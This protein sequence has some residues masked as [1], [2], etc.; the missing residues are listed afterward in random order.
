MRIIYL[1]YFLYFSN[2]VFWQESENNIGVL[3]KCV[4]KDLFDFKNYLFPMHL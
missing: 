4:V 2:T 3:E 1:Y